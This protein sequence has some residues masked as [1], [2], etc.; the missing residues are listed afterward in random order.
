[1][2]PPLEVRELVGPIS[3][4]RGRHIELVD[5]P[6]TE[7]LAVSFSLDDFD[8]VAMREHT[9]VW[10]ADHSLAHELGH[11]LCGHLEG[12]DAG[13]GS[14]DAAESEDIA[15]I[16]ARFGEGR[17]PRGGVRRRLCYDTPQEQAVEFIA[18]TFLEWSIIPGK[19]PLHL[20]R[21]MGPASALYR[22]LSYQRGWM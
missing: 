20:A 4:L 14:Y 12:D 5:Y 17:R 11:I 19:A 16:V 2:T 7:E 15:R 22:T 18:T 9:S 6:L 8:V 13:Y 1:M 21:E 3:T 10:H